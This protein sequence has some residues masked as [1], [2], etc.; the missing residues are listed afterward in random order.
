MPSA[1]WSVSSHHQLSTIR[2]V[3]LTAGNG[4]LRFPMEASGQRCP[5]SAR[6]ERFTTDHEEIC[7]G[8]MNERSMAATAASETARASVSCEN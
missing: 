2:M 8:G 3:A 6:T 5:P 4:P 1:V 7:K